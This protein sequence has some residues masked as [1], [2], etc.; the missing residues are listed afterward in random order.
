MSTFVTTF[1]SFKGGVG[2][3]TLL[4][5]VAHVLAERG[6]RVLI[7]DLDLEAPGIHLFPG[8]E[9]PDDLWQAGFLEWLGDTPPCPTSEPTSAW[10]ADGWVRM[11]GDRVYEARGS[12]GQIFI[13]PA[14]GTNVQL[15]RAYGAVDWN[16]I[17]AEQ[18]EYGLHLFTRVRD[19][20]IERFE[21]A[22]LFI[23][24]R[25]GISDLGGLLT[26]FLP[27]CTVLVGNYG[28]QST[29]GLRSVYLALDRFATERV[30]AEIYRTSKLE[31]LLVV[32][33]VP[34]SL[35]ARERGRKRWIDGFTG[36]APRSLIEVPLVESLLY[37]EDVLVRTAPSSDAARA[38]Q[39]VAEALIGLRQA[40]GRISPQ[41]S[42]PE[43]TAQVGK[44]RVERLLILL[45]FETVRERDDSFIPD[46][47]D[48][49]ARQHMPLGD[50]IVYA[51]K[52]L[53]GTVRAGLQFSE[54][55]AGVLQN[56]KGRKPLV[57]TDGAR[58]DARSAARRAGVELRTVPGLEEQLVDLRACAAVVRRAFEDSELSRVYVGPRVATMGG[59]T[60]AA[61]DHAMSWISGD[62]SRLLLV[63]GDPGS[64][65]TSFLRRLAYELA[66]RIDQDPA[67]PIPLLIE[68]RHAKT[69]VTLESV[70]QEHLRKV[71]GWHG[72]PEAILYLLH[73]GRLIVLLDGFDEMAVSSSGGA[74]EQLRILTRPTEIPGSTPW[75]NRMI[76]SCRPV[77][78]RL[79]T[80]AIELSPFDT[81]QITH[82]LTNRL[83]PARAKLTL[84]AFYSAEP[85]VPMSLLPMM[86]ELLVQVPD[87]AHVGKNFSMATLLERYVESWIAHNPD[88]AIRPGQRAR[89]VE[90]LA[91]ELWKR[92]ADEL[93]G[94]QWVEALRATDVPLAKLTAEQID[95]VLRSAPFL[96]RSEDGAYGFWHRSILEYV[97]ARYRLRLRDS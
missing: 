73:A 97:L 95:L 40:H 78:V 88:D 54:S 60:V 42:P 18:P 34:M 35:P 79:A 93:P 37:A 26:G 16:G 28:K 80:T 30:K 43:V 92:S 81:G 48:L 36:E 96:T 23:D 91:A 59:E 90:R 14:H 3:T 61:L 84:E 94:A 62:G 69:G 10:P 83:G 46:A 4:V 7:W 67:Q 77:G 82:F 47:V 15:G 75:G 86:L 66:S 85:P 53:A 74:E 55:A 13:L 45:G 51:V 89:I 38:Y 76:V 12:H 6:E 58:D 20:L 68:L 21:P 64:G 9:P 1:Y 27:D 8:L 52:Y 31:R 19:A 57:I 72:N 17:F 65:K 71:I 50:E 32:S 87:L 70:L 24:S 44:A 29:E 39:A 33:P 41:L 5:N 22:F 49:T 63:R 11:L 25:T 56:A 2:R